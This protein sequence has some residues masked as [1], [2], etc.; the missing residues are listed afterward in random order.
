MPLARFPNEGYMT[1]KRVLDNAGGLRDR[2][3]NSSAWTDAPTSGVGGTFEY[4][5]EFYAEHADWKKV[6]DHGV[7]L[8]GYWRIP[9]QNE[10]VRI[11]TIDTESH[12]VTLAKAVPGGIGSK[13]HRPEGSGEE[14]YWLM[15]LLEAVDSPGKWCVDF[16]DQKLFFY[17]PAQPE[18][19][20]VRIADNSDPVI[21]IDGASHIILR[22]LTGR[23]G[24]RPR[25]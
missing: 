5:P 25:Y 9:W 6:L 4:R 1:M 17:P 21:R 20:Q 15:N 23:T 10:A 3:W 11:R 19:G 13:Y 14:Q 2:N 24:T 7:W 18:D 22:Q 12:T 8:K 16:K